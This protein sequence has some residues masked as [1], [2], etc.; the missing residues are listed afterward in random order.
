MYLPV[1]VNLQCQ[2]FPELISPNEFFIARNK[3]KFNTIYQHQFAKTAFTYQ[4]GAT[5][6]H[7]WISILTLMLIMDKLCS[8]T[9]SCLHCSSPRYL[10]KDKKFTYQN[11]INA[12][13][14]SWLENVWTHDQ[15]KSVYKMPQ[16]GPLFW[17]LFN[18]L[19]PIQR[20]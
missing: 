4:Q 17:L 20:S 15:E 14:D 13:L 7:F 5:A 8:M 12:F 19:W 18:H 16:V 1:F 10:K 9:L 2:E 6:M 3:R 11:S